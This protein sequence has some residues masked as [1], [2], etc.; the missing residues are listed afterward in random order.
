MRDRQTI[1]QTEAE[2]EMCQYNT[3]PTG[4]HS[5]SETS[6]LQKNEV[7]KAINPIIIGKFYPKS[8]LTYNLIIYLYI[9]Y[10]SNTLEISFRTLGRDIRTDG[11]TD[12]DDTIC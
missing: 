4:D 12:S 2:L 11:R 5:H 7:E 10:E 1:R 3:R 8:N 6:I 9:K